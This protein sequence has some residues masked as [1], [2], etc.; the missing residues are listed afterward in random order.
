MPHNNGTYYVRRDV[1]T[2]SECHAN[3]AVEAGVHTSYIHS[4]I[5]LSFTLLFELQVEYIFIWVIA[6]RWSGITIV[7]LSVHRSMQEGDKQ[8]ECSSPHTNITSIVMLS[9]YHKHF[10]TVPILMSTEQC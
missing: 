10:K 3:K 1:D 6:I 8:A 7:C 4:S 9:A 5:K 2:L